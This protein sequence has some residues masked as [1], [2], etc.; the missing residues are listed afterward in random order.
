[1]WDCLQVH[2]S[3]CVCVCLMGLYPW[4]CPAPGRGRGLRSGRLGNCPLGLSREEHHAHTHAL[5][6][7][8]RPAG[9]HLFVEML[10]IQAMKLRKL[11][12]NQKLNISWA[13]DGVSAGGSGRR[14]GSQAWFLTL[15]SNL[16]SLLGNKMAWKFAS[17][18]KDFNRWKTKCFAQKIKTSH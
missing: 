4:R 3:V 1:M 16:S 17:G 13:V 10:R 6:L 11:N 7:L 5:F 18:K 15:D 12:S 2:I 8:D 9:I 14:R